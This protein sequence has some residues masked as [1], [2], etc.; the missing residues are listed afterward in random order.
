MHIVQ[1]LSNFRLEAGGV[2]RAVLDICAPLAARGHEVTLLT[3]DP[4]DAPRNWDG[5]G[6]RPRVVRLNRAGA[7]PRLS[8]DSRALAAG[9]F[10]TVDVAHLHVVWDP[11]S[12]QLG[13]IAERAGLPYIASLHGML[14][15]WTL[16]QKALK[17]RVYLALIG[18]RFLERA[19]AVHCTAALERDESAK[20]FPRGRTVV[21][22]LM[23]DMTDFMQLP[24][25]EIARARFTTSLR[26]NAPSVLYVGRLHPIKRIEMLIDAAAELKQSGRDVQVLLA[27][28]GEAG[29]EKD[30][31]RRASERAVEERVAFLGFVS[32]REKVSLYQAAD[33]FVLPSSHENFGFVMIEAL[34]CGTPAVATKAV[35]IWPELLQSGAVRIVEP[36]S[37]DLAAT[38]AGMLD[39]RVAL[40]AMKAK[41]RQW[42]IETLHADRVVEQYESLY[43]EAASRRAR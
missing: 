14:D 37:S 13:R 5:A 38:I 41:G 16:G 26:T 18:R 27:G 4:A 43:R 31:R 9:L 24:G 8:R 35:S 1:Y 11:V 32:G 23:F 19:A 3:L 22:P 39:D 12:V 21:I 10:R 42:V 36:T 34:A 7:L 6:G 29:Y 2:T 15:D 28:T 25:P 20:H 30:L 40:A 17:K 33:L